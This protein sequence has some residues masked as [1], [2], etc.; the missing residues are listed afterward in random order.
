MR[1]NDSTANGNAKIDS[2]DYLRVGHAIASLTTQGNRLRGPCSILAR[3]H[4]SGRLHLNEEALS[5]IFSIG[6]NLHIQVNAI[7]RIV[8]A[9]DPLQDLSECVLDE[10]L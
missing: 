10:I 4:Y 5:G 8:L 2:H 9:R 7:V 1:S 6:W 3:L